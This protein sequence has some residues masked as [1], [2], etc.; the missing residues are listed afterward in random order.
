[1]IARGPSPSTESRVTKRYDYHGDSQA[2]FHST[3]PPT[4]SEGEPMSQPQTSDRTW[5][6]AA[7][8]RVVSDPWSQLIFP[9][10]KINRRRPISPASSHFLPSRDYKSNKAAGSIGLPN[11]S[12]HCDFWSSVSL[13]RRSASRSSRILITLP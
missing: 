2:L 3:Q 4:Q 9:T 11:I 7:A 10:R 1:M 8:D 13:A 6:D 12:F 5:I